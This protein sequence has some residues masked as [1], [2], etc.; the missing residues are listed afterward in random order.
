MKRF[1]IGFFGDGPWAHRALKRL[2]G[3]PE[4]AVAFVC[5]RHR[6]PDPILADLAHQA[7]IPHI[8]H[9]NVNSDSFIDLIPKVEYDLFVSMSFDQIF[10]SSLIE[11]PRLQSI[12][13]HAGKLPF[14]RGRNILNWV[15]LNDEKEFGVT[16]HKMDEGI[17]TGDILAQ[18][19]LPITD[20]DT[21]ATLLARAYKACPE[22]LVETIEALRSGIATSRRQ[23]DVHPIG[24]YCRARGKGDERLNWEWTSRE[25]FNFVRAL[26]RPGPEARTWLDTSEIRINS[27]EEMPQIRGTVVPPGRV[28]AVEAECFTVAASDS[29]VRVVEWSGTES[30]N[31]GDLLS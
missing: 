19:I 25:V 13:C 16:V 3:N 29:L 2:L 26:C 18:Q 24:S 5:S 9:Q 4:L 23:S 6:S 28:T 30:I 21:Y 22:R 1:V 11:Y 14:Y 31:I 15:L 12:N 10:R 20:E 7:A 17:D 27:V 8:V